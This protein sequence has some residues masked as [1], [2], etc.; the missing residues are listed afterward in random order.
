VSV[1]LVVTEYRPAL[2]AARAD[3]YERAR[4]RLEH[5]AATAVDLVH[6]TDTGDLASASTVVLGGS[7]AEWAVHPAADLERLG[8]AVRAYPGPVL[9]ICAGMQLLTT[10][11]GGA[12][13]AMPAGVERGFL[14]IEVVEEA[15]L[16][17]GVSA[18][19]TVFQEH[20]DEVAELPDGFRVLAR[21]EACAVQAIADDERRWWGTQFHPEE[22]D[23]DNPAGERILR[24]FFAL[25]RSETPGSGR[26]ARPQAQTFV[27]S[28]VRKPKGS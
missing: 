6:Y 1:R 24:N 4:R 14:P 5:A 26:K 11:A 8:D 25:A 12:V 15:G 10:F 17:E 7:W 13:T 22:F 16:L 20:T 28:P 19:P 9:G 21:S 23:A 27:H 3:Q 2:T 18:R